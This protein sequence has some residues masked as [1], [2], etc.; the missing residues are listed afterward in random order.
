MVEATHSG[1][2][3]TCATISDL[4]SSVVC[5]QPCASTLNASTVT[6]KITATGSKLYGLCKVGVFGL[7]CTDK[8]HSITENSWT[9][10]T[11]TFDLLKDTSKNIPLP[12]LTITPDPCYTTSW[13]VYKTA[14]NTDML[15]AMSSV[16]SI[17]SPNLVVAHDIAD[18][19]QRKTL[20][21]L[22]QL[23]FKGTTNTAT[24]TVSS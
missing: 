2:T 11:V 22:T 8:T 1:T 14:D 19:A 5:S 10:S 24:P 9:Q 18:Y 12:T 6:F 4:S 23:F 13:K 15:A 7:L 17:T 16:Y 21:G 20:Y 3:T